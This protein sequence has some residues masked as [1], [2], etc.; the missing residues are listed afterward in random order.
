[1]TTSRS[2][3]AVL[4]LGLALAAGAA[5]A[6]AIDG[7]WCSPDGKFITIKGSDVV[8]PGGA[9]MQGDYDRHHFHY[10]VPASEPGA[11]QGVFMTLQGDLL[12]LVR[13][14]ADAAAAARQTAQEWRRCA[15]P[16]SQRGA[17]IFG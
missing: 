15:P 14:G 4:A 10:V 2:R 13:V 9:R 8:T 1:M 5:H 3:G 17:R 16:T 6:D 7:N 11:G 12:V